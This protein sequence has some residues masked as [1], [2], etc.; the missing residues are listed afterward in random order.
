MSTAHAC[1]STAH[2]EQR[3]RYP[4]TNSS[5]PT[6]SAGE[7]Q[8]HFSTNRSGQHSRSS[9]LAESVGTALNTEGFANFADII[10]HLQTGESNAK[11]N[12]LVATIS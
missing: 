5:T 6:S 8:F 10:Q 4:S 12:L 7:K 2:D 1:E 11:R 9:S 3:Q